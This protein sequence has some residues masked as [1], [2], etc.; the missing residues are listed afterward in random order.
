MGKFNVVAKLSTSV[1]PFATS[2]NASTSRL[3]SK[4]TDAGL[5]PSTTVKWNFLGPKDGRFE[6]QGVIPCSDRA[7]LHAAINVLIS[8]VDEVRI[9]RVA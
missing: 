8:V 2:K 1:N 4:L 6:F 7:D 5:S 3:M 9:Q